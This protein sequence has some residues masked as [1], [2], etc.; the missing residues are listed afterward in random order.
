MLILTIK[1][2][3]KDPLFLVKYENLM[4]NE[5]FLKISNTLLACMNPNCD[6]MFKNIGARQVHM[7]SCNKPPRFKCGHCDFHSTTKKNVRLHSVAKHRKQKT[8]IIELHDPNLRRS[9]FPCPNAVC[10]KTFDTQERVTFHI[11]YRCCKSPRFK[12]FYCDFK[13][14]YKYEVKLH[15]N[16]KHADRQFHVIKIEE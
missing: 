2:D 10:N 3:T 9:S 4:P 7:K 8:E 14:Y 13:S 12:C 5:E 6:K 16:S 1:Y 15:N 11:K